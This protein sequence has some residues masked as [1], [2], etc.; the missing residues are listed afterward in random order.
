MYS[1]GEARKDQRMNLTTANTNFYV[2]K[3]KQIS[4]WLG[5]KGLIMEI[6]LFF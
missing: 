4:F 5:I 2:Q 6:Y 1:S 3:T